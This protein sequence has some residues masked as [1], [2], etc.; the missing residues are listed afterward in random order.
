MTDYPAALRG[1]AALLTPDPDDSDAWLSL[2]D[3][4]MLLHWSLL[5]AGRQRLPTHAPTACLLV[6][7]LAARYQSAGGYIGTHAGVRYLH[8]PPAPHPTLTLL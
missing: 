7:A 8:S 2:P 1:L 6:T 4:G 5:K 3:L